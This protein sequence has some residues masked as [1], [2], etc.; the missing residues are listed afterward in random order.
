MNNQLSIFSVILMLL[1]SLLSSIAWANNECYNK[2]SGIPFKGYIPKNFKLAS[3]CPENQNQQ[4]GR[5]EDVYWLFI[6]KAR[7]NG[8]F[9]LDIYDDG[10]SHGDYYLAFIPQKDQQH[11]LPNSIEQ[12]DFD[13]ISDIKGLLKLPR[14][15]AKGS[16]CWEVKSGLSVSVIESISND[17]DD[18][19]E[20]AREFKIIQPG[21]SWTKCAE[22]VGRN[23]IVP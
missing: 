20:Y 9:R 17:A 18:S 19:G 13:N 22:H 7:L 2:T 5:K 8:Y 16:K 23:N 6:G 15:K 12:L 4:K 3:I 21:K 1:I 10:S 14:F 11:L